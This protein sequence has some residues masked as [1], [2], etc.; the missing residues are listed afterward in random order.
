MGFA[1]MAKGLI[2]VGEGFV[3]LAERVV[4]Y[5][6]DFL[7]FVQDI[8]AA[9]AKILADIADWAADNLF[10]LELLE[11]NG[12]LDNDFNACVGM[13]LK[14]VIVGFRINFDGKSHLKSLK[15]HILNR[16]P[17]FNFML[18]ESLNFLN[19]LHT[20]YFH[21]IL[22]KLILCFLHSSILYKLISHLII[23]YLIF[24]FILHRLTLCILYSFILYKLIS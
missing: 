5:A 14:C 8:V 18:H 6:A 2:S 9:G 7:H 3:S 21:F 15:S 24:Y 4:D 10:K 12:K 1:D 22:Y 13:K 19:E 16:A 11:L 23:S 17:W 20:S